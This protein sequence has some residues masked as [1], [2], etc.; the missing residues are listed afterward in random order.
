MARKAA[1]PTLVMLVQQIKPECWQHSADPEFVKLLE[2]A[3]QANNL[4]KDH[5]SRVDLLREAVSAICEYIV[6]TSGRTWRDGTTAQ[7]SSTCSM[8]NCMRCSGGV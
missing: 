7:A 8:T 2:L 5:P 3:H 6:T 4:P 1:N